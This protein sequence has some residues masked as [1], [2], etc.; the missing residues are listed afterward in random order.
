MKLYKIIILFFLGILIGWFI[1]DCHSPKPGIPIT[2]HDTLK[3]PTVTYKLLPGAYYNVD[4]LINV[5][6]QFWKDSLKNLYGHGLFE[7]KFSK[8][9]ALGKRQYTLESRIPIDP[10]SSLIVDE[11]FLFPK[12]TLGIIAGINSCWKGSV[13]L[14]Y[15]LLDHKNYSLTGSASCAYEFVK[16]TWTPNAKLE[17]EIKI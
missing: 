10:Q 17:L 1:P 2:I 11:S 7:S 9:D 15:Y 14:K 13:G 5:I 16:K 3:L 12:R 4:S 6:N 8:E